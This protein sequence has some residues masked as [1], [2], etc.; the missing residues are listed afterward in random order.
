MDSPQIDNTTCRQ[1]WSANGTCCD[2][3][4]LLEFSAA[5]RKRV[6]ESVEVVKS[7]SIHALASCSFKAKHEEGYFRALDSMARSTATSSTF[8]ASIDQCWDH[9]SGIRAKTLCS[10]CSGRSA[11]FFNESKGVITAPVCSQ[12]L[13]ACLPSFKHLFTFLTEFDNFLGFLYNA[14]DLG[15]SPT[16][17]VQK[18]KM[19]SAI[20]RLSSTVDQIKEKDII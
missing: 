14:A 6:L 12:T 3:Q 7:F 2:K 18:E 10:T 5:D 16:A 11:L 9:M 17:L 15:S 8:N 13:R 19:K 4:S 1:E 20:R